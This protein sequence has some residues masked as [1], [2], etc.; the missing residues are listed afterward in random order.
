MDVDGIPGA[1]QLP[2]GGRDGLGPN[3]A[4]K[5]LWCPLPWLE[6]SPGITPGDGHKAMEKFSCSK[7]R[8]GRIVLCLGLLRDK[9]ISQKPL[10][11]P[12]L[13]HKE[14]CKPRTW[15]GHQGR[16]TLPFLSC[17]PSFPVLGGSWL[18][19]EGTG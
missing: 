17:L 19:Q 2:A 3:R 9:G 7:T 14:I 11:S 5:V 18:L 6:P 16:T 13:Q 4:E 12:N 1:V 10:E 15:E 8:K